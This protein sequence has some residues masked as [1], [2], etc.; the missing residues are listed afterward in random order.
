MV[1]FINATETIG[2]IIASGTANVTGSIIATLLFVFMVLV[3]ICLMFQIP[4]EIGSL[5]L[6]P[7]VIG[8]ASYYS[9]FMIALVVI[10]IMVATLIAKNWLFR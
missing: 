8:V 5:L 1:F 2:L 4:V 10:L 6:L 9:D 3:V 7:F